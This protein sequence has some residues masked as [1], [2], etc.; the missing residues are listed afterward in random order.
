MVLNT[1]LTC[2]KLNAKCPIQTQQG[3][4]IIYDESGFLLILS[5]PNLSEKEIRAFNE[6]DITINFSIVDNEGFFIIN[7]DNLIDNSDI[8]FTFN[9]TNNLENKT[10][11]EIISEEYKIKNVNEGYAFNLVLVEQYGNI[12]KG[13][14]VL[15]LGTEISLAI[16]EYYKKCLANK[17]TFSKEI[18]NN[19]ILKILKKYTINNILNNSIASYITKK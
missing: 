12:I 6:D 19:K 2:F 1:M 17:D 13:L 14:R 9:L 10:L 18:Y 15:G 5:L 16:N 8:A 7:I 3:F 4:Q 11:D